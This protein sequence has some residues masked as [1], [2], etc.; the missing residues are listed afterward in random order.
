M[1]NNRSKTVLWKTIQGGLLAGLVISMS[2]RSEASDRLNHRHDD[3]NQKAMEKAKSA[4]E[5]VVSDDIG[6]GPSL[7]TNLDAQIGL[8]RTVG[9]TASK[10]ADS[11]LFTSLTEQ[12]WNGLRE[13]FLTEM[14]AGEIEHSSPGARDASLTKA[15]EGLQQRI[16]MRVAQV[17]SIGK[18]LE[19]LGKAET[20]MAQQ[21]EA[22][23][24]AATTAISN[25]A[26]QTADVA[27]NVIDVVKAFRNAVVLAGQRATEEPGVRDQLSELQRTILSLAESSRDPAAVYALVAVTGTGLTDHTSQLLSNFLSYLDKELARISNGVPETIK[28]ARA[29]KAGERPLTHLESTFVDSVR[30]AVAW[31]GLAPKSANDTPATAKAK[32]T[33]GFVSGI[34]NL[35]SSNDP[36]GDAVVRILAD[37]DRAAA[38]LTNTANQLPK[39]SKEMQSVLDTL[40]VRISALDTLLKNPQVISNTLVKLGQISA[41]AKATFLLTNFLPPKV[42]AEIDS[43]EFQAA[44][45]QVGRILGDIQNEAQAENVRLL[46]FFSDLAKAELGIYQEDARHYQ[47]LEQICARELRRWHSIYKLNSQYQNLYAAVSSGWK[48]PADR[49]APVTHPQIRLFSEQ[50]YFT[51]WSAYYDWKLSHGGFAGRGLKAPELKDVP[52]PPA[53]LHDDEI[54][55]SVRLLAEE[56]RS[57]QRG[58]PSRLDPLGVYAQFTYKRLWTAT[59]LIS[60][61]TLMIGLDE[62]LA[63]ENSRLLAR[64]IKEHDIHLDGLVARTM[65]ADIRLGLGDQV[66]FH[67]GGW[68]QDDVKVLFDII[69]SAAVVYIGGTL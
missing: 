46:M 9:Q 2:R 29:L 51:N 4:F 32:L 6:L 10:V 67:S 58:S 55:P 28:G 36:A 34:T 18:V 7:L 66:A 54:L 42:S 64:E 57:F 56:A 3:N 65:E 60:G 53:V 48:P 19:A 21:V 20:L 35:L 5:T 49:N 17:G 41:D 61:Y 37:A 43:K 22:Q 47:S 52:A 44:V 38:N 59:Q 16:D 33:P 1:I 69:Q 62:R 68:T 8:M 12:T 25:A 30:E 50:D 40:G 24:A 45:K 13:K 15:Q 11:D 39:I 27:T 63:E 26:P 14:G 31:V 23:V